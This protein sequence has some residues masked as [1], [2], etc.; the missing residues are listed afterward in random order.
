MSCS[1]FGPDRFPPAHKQPPSHPVPIPDSEQPIP[2]MKPE[3]VE[4][5]QPEKI[6]VSCS[7]CASFPWC[8][9]TFFFYVGG[10]VLLLGASVVVQ[11]RRRRTQISES[12]I[13]CFYYYLILIYRQFFLKHH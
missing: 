3:Q 5:E 2:G 4:V 7:G 6:N 8:V 13:R 11:E 1:G 9:S 12:E 10:L